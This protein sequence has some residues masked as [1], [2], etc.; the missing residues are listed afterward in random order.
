MKRKS[1]LRLGAIASLVLTAGVAIGIATSVMGHNGGLR[2]RATDHDANCHWNHYE[3][4]AATYESHGSK[5]F[6]ACCTHAGMHSL[7]E[8]VEGHI[9]DMGPFSGEFFD[10]LDP[11]DDRY[12]PMLT[13][14]NK[15]ARLDVIGWQDPAILYTS[16]QYT[17]VTGVSMKLRVQGEYAAYSGNW[18]TV[19]VSS[20]HNNWTSGVN[21]ATAGNTYFTDGEWHLVHVDIGPATGYVN[22]CYNLDHSMS[23]SIDVDD[24]TVETSTG[25]HCETFESNTMMEFDANHVRISAEA[26]NNRFLRED[27]INAQDEQASVHTSRMFTAVTNVS[28]KMRIPSGCG[29]WGNVSVANNNGIYTDTATAWTADG[30]WHLYSKDFASVDGYIKFGHEQGHFTGPIDIDDVVITYD[31]GKVAIDTFDGESVFMTYKLD[32]AIVTS[33]ERGKAVGVVALDASISSVKAKEYSPTFDQSK[34]VDATYGSYIQLDNWQCKNDQNRCWVALNATE[35]LPLIKH[36]LGGE[37]SSYYFYMYNPLDENFQLNI[38][39]NSSYVTAKAFTLASKAWTRISMNV[40]TYGGETLTTPEQM[41]LDHT[42][43]SDGAVV[44][45]GWKISSIYAEKAEPT[46]EPAPFGVVA[47]NAQ[48]GYFRDTKGYGAPHTDTNGVDNDYGAYIQIDDWACPAGASRCWLTFS[49]TAK[50]VSDIETELGGSITDYFFYIYNPLAEN[51]TMNIM[52]KSSS[53]MN[54]NVNVTCVAGEW[55]KVTVEYNHAD[56]GSYPALTLASQIGLDHTFGSNGA[57]V[58]S[59]W[60]VTSVYAEQLTD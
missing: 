8:P 13:G 56:N 11:L 17:A 44:G 23:G 53:G 60:K 15:F 48:S 25:T 22:F 10:D 16:E 36:R 59:G 51:F 45:S 30:E 54:P 46:P 4:V 12:V 5:E 34:G 7:D 47:L 52:L 39:L 28:Y 27:S 31:G 29:A 26:N 19:N 32:K 50:S 38:I 37:V 49:D 6:W 57:V 41:G 40:G 20:G 2:L 14:G 3:A 35:S 24:F 1:L 42:F 9:T 18:I 33:E 43:G 21:I 55:T 58:G